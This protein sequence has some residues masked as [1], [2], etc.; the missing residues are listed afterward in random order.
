VMLALASLV[1][2]IPMIF[3]LVISQVTAGGARPQAG[4][5]IGLVPLALFLAGVWVVLRYSMGPLMSWSE[6]TFRLF[7]SW[8]FTRGRVLIM[9]AVGVSVAVIVLC[10][11]VVLFSLLALAANA[12]VPVSALPAAMASDP[13]AVVALVAPVLIAALVAFPLLATWGL[14]MFG[15][16]WA[17]MYRQLTAPDA[18]PPVASDQVPPVEPPHRDGLQV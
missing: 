2:A 4:F 8:D 18:G 7:E 12:I 17:E 1:L 16:A 10:G 13:K 14:V 9:L 5:S 15:A 11:E 6:R 3:A